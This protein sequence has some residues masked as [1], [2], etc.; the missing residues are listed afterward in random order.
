MRSRTRRVFASFA[1]L[2]ALV[3]ARGA[4]AQPAPPPPA[5]PVVPLPPPTP[6]GV[7][8]APDPL[9]VALEPVRGGLT[10]EEVAR[11]ASATRA[12]VR[13][14]QEELRV[15]QARVDQA[16]V[17]FFPRVSVSASYT[18]TS[19]LNLAFGGSI[20]G[21]QAS[22]PVTVGACSPGAK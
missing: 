20:I 10:A 22:G 8:P 12:S 5:R 15:A 19:P 16:L 11:V 2:A 21:T 4:S 1:A 17:Q 3:S 6:P 9:A 13:T 14:K 18:R 7:T